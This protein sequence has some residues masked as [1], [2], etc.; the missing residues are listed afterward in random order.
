[1]NPPGIDSSRW[2]GELGGPFIPPPPIVGRWPELKARGGIQGKADGCTTLFVF[3]PL[4]LLVAHWLARMAISDLLVAAPSL[5]LAV[6]GLMLFAFALNCLARIGIFSRLCL[7]VAIVGG[8]AVPVGIVAYL[9]VAIDAHRSAAVGPAQRAEIVSVKSHGRHSFGATTRFL[10]QD[11]SLVET[12]DYAAFGYGAASRCFSVR[13]LRGANG[14]AW[15][16]VVDA[17]PVPGPGQ[18]A[19]PIDREACFSNAPLSALGR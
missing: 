17:S 10:L 5:G 11:G 7:W 3:V 13:V 15:I 14:F 18:L 19:W 16:R 4:F 1:M 8:A 12:D 2:T 9:V 6:L